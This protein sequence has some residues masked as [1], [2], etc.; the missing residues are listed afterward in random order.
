MPSRNIHLTG[1]LFINYCY[2]WIYNKKNIPHCLAIIDKTKFFS[3]LQLCRH[4][5]LYMQ[6]ILPITRCTGQ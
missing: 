4:L 5:T 1:F 2:L 3:I 6:E